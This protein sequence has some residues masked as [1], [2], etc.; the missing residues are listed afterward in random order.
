VSA[1]HEIEK[2]LRDADLKGK[3][4]KPRLPA[5]AVVTAGDIGP[6]FE[7]E[8]YIALGGA[9]RESAPAFARGGPAH[10]QEE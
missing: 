7:I 8:R 5:K 1:R 10:T 4:A 3:R 2:A 9:G 6:R